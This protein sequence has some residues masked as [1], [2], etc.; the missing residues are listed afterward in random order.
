[1]GYPRKALVCLSDTPYYHVVARCV[2][3]A[4]LWGFDEYADRD[5]SRRKQW[6]IERLELLVSIFAIDICAYAI[7]SNHFHLVPFTLESYLKL[8]DWSG[9]IVRPDKRGAIDDQAPPILT[10][11]GIDPHVWQNAMALRGNVF[12]RALGRLDRL[13]LHAKALGQERIKGLMQARRLYRTT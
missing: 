1:M 2:R 10:R 4:W 11:L 8:L 12:G 5:Y 6:V 13:R 7:M 9:R 3:R